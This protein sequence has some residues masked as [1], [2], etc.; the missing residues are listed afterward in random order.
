MN[1]KHQV[2]N[3]SSQLILFFNGWS[4]DYNI[5]NHL[6]A[7]DFDIITFDAYTKD[8]VVDWAILSSYK[9]INIVAY[10]FGVHMANYVCQNIHQQ[11]TKRIAINGTGAAVSNEFGI[12]EPIFNKTLQTL[13]VKNIMKFYRRICGTNSVYEFFHHQMPQRSLISQIE[14]LEFLGQLPKQPTQFI[15]WDAALIAKDDA[16]FP[17]Q[18][19]IKYWQQNQTKIIEIESNH[20]PFHLWKTWT[21][22]IQLAS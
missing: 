6:N 18:N 10:S 3:K 17:Y 9:E 5:V 2:Q 7:D 19:Q 12:P 11:V 8:T 22:L 15:A 20:Y 16:I 14:E 4:M 1:L 21:Q 13:S